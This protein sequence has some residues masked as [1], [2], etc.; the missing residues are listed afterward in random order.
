MSV[1][2]TGRIYSYDDDPISYEYITIPVDFEYR[3]PE[4]PFYAFLGPELGFL[5]SAELD[6]E[7]ISNYTPGTQFGFNIGV[8]AKIHKSIALDARYYKGFSSVND[9]VDIYHS[10]LLFGLRYFY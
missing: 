7:D 9:H 6:G 10:S 8:G 2:Y 3:F 1:T 5:L 4:S